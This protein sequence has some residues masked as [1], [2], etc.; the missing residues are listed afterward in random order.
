MMMMMMMMMVLMI[1]M[2]PLPLLLLMTV[3]ISVSPFFVLFLNLPSRQLGRQRGPFSV[4]LFPGLLGLLMFD[5][6]GYVYDDCDDHGCDDWY[7]SV[8]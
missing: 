8:C 6:D 4:R 2:M 5:G 1:L 3:A 7:V